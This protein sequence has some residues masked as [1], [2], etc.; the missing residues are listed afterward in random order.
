MKSMEVVNKIWEI[1]KAIAGIGVLTL[2]L[3]III[4][5]GSV[6]VK[7]TFNTLNELI[8]TLKNM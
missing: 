4:F 2:W 8:K 5:G 6:N 1:W 7:V 3:L